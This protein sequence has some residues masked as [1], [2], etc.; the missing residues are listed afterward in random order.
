VKR[1]LLHGRTIAFGEDLPPF[2][3]Y[4]SRKTFNAPLPE[5]F[6]LV[7][8]KRGWHIYSWGV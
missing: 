6:L 7:L 1:P 8:R 5:D 3:K 2:I 4:L